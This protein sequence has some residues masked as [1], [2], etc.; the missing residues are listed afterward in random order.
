VPLETPVQVANA[1]AERGYNADPEAVTLIAAADDTAG[2]LERALETVPDDAVKLT[3]DH[4]RRATDPSHAVDSPAR[5]PDDDATESSPDPATDPSI[6]TGTTPS[7]SVDDGGRVPVETKGVDAPDRDPDAV[8]IEGDF[9]STGTGEYADFVSVF[10]DRYEKLSGKLRSRVNH[11]PT[12]ALESM[13]GNSEAAIVG[14]V[15]DIRS[16]ASGHWLVELEDTNGTFP[17]LVMKDRE[18]AHLVD[19][20]LLDEVIAVE[21][22]LADDGGILFV[23]AMHFPDIPGPTSRRRPTARYRRR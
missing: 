19:E 1:L 7:V 15:S 9:A 2:A 4:A 10:R 13:P 20:L 23:D 12:D 11:R 3:T 8:A 6:S 22:N 5:A 16:T 17:C 18:F 14:M 21:G